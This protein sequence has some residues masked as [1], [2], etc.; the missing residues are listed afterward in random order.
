MGEVIE[1]SI[2]LLIRGS[3]IPLNIVAI[4]DL[5]ISFLPVKE[6]KCITFVELVLY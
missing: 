4:E 6:I 3:V 1:F 5:F 2:I